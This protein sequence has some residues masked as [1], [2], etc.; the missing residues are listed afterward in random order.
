VKPVPQIPPGA[1]EWRFT[2]AQGIYDHSDADFA[3][4]AIPDEPRAVYDQDPGFDH[5]VF[6][7]DPSATVSMTWRERMP[8][9]FKLLVPA[10]L[11]GYLSDTATEPPAVGS[12]ASTV[13]VS[14]PPS[15]STPTDLG[16][17]AAFVARCKAAGVRAFVDAS[18]PEWILGESILRA[19]DASTGS[20]IDAAPT[21][22]RLEGGDLLVPIDPSSP[23][24]A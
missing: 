2:V 23:P 19:S 3:V 9:A 17:I 6:D 12:A 18:R 11:P 4:Y 13:P 7:F 15:P 14:P 16:R 1:T 21:L 8:C 20:G 24:S 22:L 5:A 10:Q